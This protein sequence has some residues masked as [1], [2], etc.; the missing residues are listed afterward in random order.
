[1]GEHVIESGLMLSTPPAKVR[2]DITNHPVK[3]TVVEQL[4][5]QR[6]YMILTKLVIQS[7]DKEEYLLFSGFTSSGKMLDQEICEK[8]MMCQ[9]Q[10][11]ERID[12]PA[13]VVQK[14][15]QESERYCEATV[16]RVMEANNKFFKEEQDRLQK[17][18]DDLIQASEKELEDIKVRLRE[19]SR[20]AR[21]AT[22]TEEQHKIQL[23]IAELEKQKKEKRRRI[24]EVEDEILEKRDALIKELEM[25]MMQKVEKETLFMI[26]WEI[27]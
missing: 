11:V 5:G 15:Q 27:V 4:K 3:I 21:L 20:Q 19:L 9:G 16:S 25:K 10:V 12:L 17:W 22:T 14:L 7:F 2:F 13:V 8:I 1:L 26:E 23:Q 18:A 6:G 24:F